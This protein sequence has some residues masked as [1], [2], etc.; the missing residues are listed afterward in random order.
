MGK[1]FG[2]IGFI[3]FAA[4][5]HAQVPFPAGSIGA[6][7]EVELK[8]LTTGCFGD[9]AKYGPAFLPPDF[10]SQ[11]GPGQSLRKPLTEGLV[12]E[13]VQF[14]YLTRTILDIRSPIVPQIKEAV[15]RA[16]AI[17][18]KLPAATPIT[19]ADSLLYNLNCGSQLKL[20]LDQGFKFSFN[21]LGNASAGIKQALDF[22]SNPTARG[23][24]LI[25]NGV[26]LSPLHVALTSKDPAV[27]ATSHASVLTFLDSSRNRGLETANLGYLRSIKGWLVTLG[28]NSETS[29]LLR[30]SLDAS[31]SGFGFD[32]KVATSS[33][34][35]YSS[36]LSST[37]FLIFL[38][39][40]IVPKDDVEKLPSFA[41]IQEAF[42]TAAKS[43]PPTEVTYQRGGK[44]PFRVEISGM[45]DWL[46]LNQWE[47]SSQDAENID[48]VTSLI[49]SSNKCVLSTSA[50]ISK[51]ISEL[52]VQFTNQK[53][54]SGGPGTT[55]LKLVKQYLLKQA[56]TPQIARSGDV[57]ITPNRNA[58]VPSYSIEAPFSIYPTDTASQA[59]L[60]GRMQLKCEGFEGKTTLYP[61]QT[62]L[63][64]SQS[65]YRLNIT[66]NFEPEAIPTSS[67]SLVAD[68]S[69]ISTIDGTTA[70][71]VKELVLEVLRFSPS[72]TQ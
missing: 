34:V 69:F 47:A 21:L 7:M 33:R 53:Y 10:T 36:N 18:L 3:I 54:S 64:G 68:V 23:S 37:R 55:K 44:F 67:C 43:Y 14:S 1:R 31:A 56:S 11:F 52:N 17:D 2:L 30:A 35:E 59:F 57:I 29:Q 40:E 32:A 60:P 48:R 27:R 41:S 20:A 25:M 66:V 61:N 42:N 58:S 6:R 38:D 72:S 50:T 19:E 28:S 51:E 24:I 9:Y 22:Q 71:I 70:Q 8:A 4:L 13:G 26:F 49:D 62:A 5:A 65:R 45:P 12:I 15:G 39:R 16:Y 63:D 46:C